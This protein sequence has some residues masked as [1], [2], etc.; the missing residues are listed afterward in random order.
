MSLIPTICSCTCNHRSKTNGRRIRTIV[1]DLQL[2]ADMERQGQMNTT[3]GLEDRLA[4]TAR[5]ATT[6]NDHLVDDRMTIIEAETT[7]DGHHHETHMDHRRPRDENHTATIPTTEA[8]PHHP[9]AMALIPMREVVT[10]TVAGQGL[11]HE[12]AME[13]GMQLSMIEEDT[14][15]FPASIHDLALMPSTE[16]QL[17]E[18]IYI[19]RVL[20]GNIIAQ[21]TRRIVDGSGAGLQPPPGREHGRNFPQNGELLYQVGG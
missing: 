20:R 16:S 14:I 3:I 12:Q 7:D 8:R 4:V 18:L 15:E 19:D 11:R 10:R 9:E 13:A 21:R 6:V 5:A 17:L 2:V 1:N